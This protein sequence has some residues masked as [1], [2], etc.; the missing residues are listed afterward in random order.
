MDDAAHPT[1]PFEIARPESR[2]DRP[3]PTVTAAG[4]G[5]PFPPLST[6]IAALDEM[7][8]GGLVRGAVVD[9]FGPADACHLDVGFCALRAAQGVGAV[10][11][12][13]D[14]ARTFDV[15]EAAKDGLDV[16]RLLVSQPDTLEQAF[17][18]IEAVARSGAVDLIVVN[19]LPA[20]EPAVPGDEGAEG[21]FFSEKV[22]SLAH[23]CGRSGTVL[24]FLRELEVDAPDPSGPAVSFHARTRI[25]VFRR[26]GF[27]HARVTK[28]PT[29]GTGREALLTLDT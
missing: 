1:L 3:E 12:I 2:L 10:A 6:G 27:V 17:E 19:G 4:A 22:G 26:E 24:V 29:G 21:R 7:L 9:V 20:A 13:Y 8:S 28:H 11:A 16:A 18:S 5:S 23:V 15:V 14:C 25:N